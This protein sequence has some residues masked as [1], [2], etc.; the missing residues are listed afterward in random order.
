MAIVTGAHRYGGH[1]FTEESGFC[2]SDGTP[3]EATIICWRH[4]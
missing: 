2:E 1:S 4:E 3:V